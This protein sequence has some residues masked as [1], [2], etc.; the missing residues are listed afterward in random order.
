M[1]CVVEIG[2]PV[3]VAR[4]TVRA[5]ARATAKRNCSEPTSESGTRPLPENR[6][7]SASA[8]KIEVIEPASCVMVAHVSAVR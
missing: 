7:N 3:T 6:F 5:A 1:A 8:R 2:K 4:M